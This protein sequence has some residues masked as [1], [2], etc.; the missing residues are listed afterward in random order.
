MNF[1][2]QTISQLEKRK[3][4]RLINS[5]SGFKS[6]NLIGT[7][8]DKKN[9][10]L[11]IFSS[12]VHLGSEP[13]LLA[14]ISRPH[15]VERHTLE[16]ILD[17]GYFTINHVNEAIFKQAHQTSARY[18][19]EQSEYKE[20]G[21][22]PEWEADFPAP[23][24]KECSIRLGM[25][26]REK[27]HLDINDTEMI[28]G[29]IAFIHLPGHLLDDDGYVHLEKANIVTVSSLDSY[30]STQLLSHLSY[31]KTDSEIETLNRK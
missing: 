2:R 1:N 4:A 24:V 28:I 29:E 9:T 8:D 7:C 31:A 23:F 3:K 20:V 30:H 12:V 13:P 19:N 15:T 16:N 18:S 11:A 5:L 21:L 26:F 27:I 10:N 25:T 6:A 17:T 14:L 22:T